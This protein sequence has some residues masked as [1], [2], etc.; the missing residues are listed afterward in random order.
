MARFCNVFLQ[1]E[2]VYILLLNSPHLSLFSE[3]NHRCQVQLRKNQSLKKTDKFN[4]LAMCQTTLIVLKQILPQ[5]HNQGHVLKE[6]T[7]QKLDIN[8]LILTMTVW[9]IYSNYYLER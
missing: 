1:Y 6:L 8:D 3:Y 2:R 9:E 5:L 4:K 7:G